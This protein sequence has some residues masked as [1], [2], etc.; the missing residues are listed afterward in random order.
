MQK[1]MFNLY[2]KKKAQAYIEDWSSQ[3][4]SYKEFKVD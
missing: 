2:Q 1:R 4:K 3:N